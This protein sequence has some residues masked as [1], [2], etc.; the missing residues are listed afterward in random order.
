MHDPRFFRV[1]RYGIYKLFLDETGP[2]TLDETN[3]KYLDNVWLRKLDD[4][5]V[6]RLERP[7]NDRQIPVVTVG[8]N[9]YLLRIVSRKER[10]PYRPIPAVTDSQSA[11]LLRIVQ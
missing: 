7:P 11:H 9:A 6:I 8:P 5:S 4:T 10:P 3:F 1:G 2:K